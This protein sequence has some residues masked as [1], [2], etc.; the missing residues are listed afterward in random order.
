VPS[1]AAP[2]QPVHALEPALAGAEEA[3]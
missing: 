2:R 1:R 3:R